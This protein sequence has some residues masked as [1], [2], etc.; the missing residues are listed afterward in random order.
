MLRPLS[1]LASFKRG[2]GK[3]ATCH[4]HKARMEQKLRVQHFL[5]AKGDHRLFDKVYTF[6]WTCITSLLPCRDDA[7]RPAQPTPPPPSEATVQSACNLLLAA[8]SEMLLGCP[9]SQTCCVL[10]CF[11]HATPGS[12]GQKLQEFAGSEFKQMQALGLSFE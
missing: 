1:P 10:R 2:N 4:L 12:Q 11:E 6:S 3:M 9:P 7:Q 8:L 5:R